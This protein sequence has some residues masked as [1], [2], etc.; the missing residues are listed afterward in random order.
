[1]ATLEQLDG[2]NWGDPES[3]ET[4][5]IRTCLSL[6]RK[7]IETFSIEN[8]RVLLSQSIGVQ[9]LVPLALVH[10]K[11]DPFVEGDLYPGDLL[12]AFLTP[13]NWSELEVHAHEAEVVCEAALSVLN[14]LK[15]GALDDTRFIGAHVVDHLTSSIRE[16][17]NR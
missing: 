5:L 11:H 17:I 12:V 4:D 8:L 13:R 7:Q 15:D 9:H 14:V 10:L 3:G 16:Y 2:Q 1:M 6:R